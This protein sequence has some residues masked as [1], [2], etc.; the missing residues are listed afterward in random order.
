MIKDTERTLLRYFLIVDELD[1]SGESTICSSVAYLRLNVFPTTE[2]FSQWSD[3]DRM[4]IA[5]EAISSL[6]HDGL[7]EFWEPTTRSRT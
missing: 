1:D 7:V 3:A 4:R 6:G 2:P 5:I